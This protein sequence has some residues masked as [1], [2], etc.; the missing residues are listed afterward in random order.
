MTFSVLV[1]LSVPDEFSFHFVRADV[2]C[3]IP[4]ERVQSFT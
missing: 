1:I 2:D 4:T 3:P